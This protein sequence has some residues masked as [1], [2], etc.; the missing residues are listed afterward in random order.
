[1]SDAAPRDADRLHADLARVW[2]RRPGWRGWLADV[3]HSAIG[4][5]FMLLAAV[6]FAI[7]GVLAMLIRVQLA[8]PKA[9]FVGP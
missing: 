4:I 8:H 9:A 3:N 7:G 1:M 2:S 5:R 6:Y